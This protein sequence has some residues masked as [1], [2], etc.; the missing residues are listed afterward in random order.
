[1]I[2]SR[3]GKSYETS[4]G[5]EQPHAALAAESGRWGSGGR[6]A[7]GRR[8]RAGRSTVPAAGPRAE[9]GLERAVD[10]ETCSRHADGQAGATR[11]PAS[12]RTPSGRPGIDSRG[13]T[14]GAPCGACP[15]GR[16]RSISQRMGEH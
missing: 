12:A 15:E 1:M 9:A 8:R 13:R 3:D 14:P 5:S 4:G 10:A 2:V 6:G 11:P 16:A 7:V